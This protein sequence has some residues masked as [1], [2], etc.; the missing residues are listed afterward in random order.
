MDPERR[1]DQ[2]HLPAPARR[3]A[4]FFGRPVMTWFALRLR[5]R[6]KKRIL[7]YETAECIGFNGG[8]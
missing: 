4:P 2:R 5:W 1:T 7:C 3:V 6:A 8:H